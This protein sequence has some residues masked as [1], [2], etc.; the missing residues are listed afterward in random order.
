MNNLL[1]EGLK[2]IRLHIVATSVIRLPKSVRWTLGP[3]PLLSVLKWFDCNLFSYQTDCVQGLRGSKRCG[4]EDHRGVKENRKTL[5]E[6]S[7]S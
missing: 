5:Q 3:F 7:E 1:G 4:K 6:T 2:E